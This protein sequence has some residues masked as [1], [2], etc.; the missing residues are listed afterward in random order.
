[1]QMTDLINKKKKG[2]ALSR[3]EISFLIK[4]ITAGEIPDYQ[5][6]ALCMAI[7]FQGMEDEETA[8]LTQAM[9]DSGDK[10]D[11][12]EFGSFSVDKHST[13]GVGDKTTLILAPLVA[14][15]GAKVAKMSGRGLGHT[16]GTV[17]KLEA[18]PGYR[19]RLPEEE[20]RQIARKAGV[21]VVG[22][23]AELAPADKKLYALRDVT[24]TV[25]S[26]PLIV[27]S[28]MSKKI[29]AGAHSIVLDVTVGSGAFMKTIEDARILAE[30][31]VTIG[32]ACGRRMTALITDMNEPLGHAVGNALEVREAI[33]VLKGETE[34][35][36]KEI[37]LALASEM[38][39]L[40]LEMPH[41]EA[42]ALA[43]ECLASGRAFE[44]CREWVAAQG[45]DV[46]YLMEPERF[47]EAAYSLMIPSPREGYLAA[48]DTQAIGEVACLLGA[49]RKR[50]EDSIDMAAGIMLHAKLGD[51]LEEGQPLATLYSEKEDSL[52]EAKT[53]YLEAL[54]FRKERI[55]K[56][57][58]IY[59]IIRES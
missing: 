42:R 52:R 43:E 3:E 4:G 20:F 24:G 58:L 22:Q 44:K 51:H 48:M 14:A 32:R 31:M 29:A 13:G 21:C 1:M 6:S 16:G 33:K 45:G 5:T 36:L 2:E 30:K 41:E 11:L 28:I 15:C 53:R 27:S 46:T 38:L 56:P 7:C 47:P 50:Q 10:L 26:I 59:D 19:T 25:D 12:S 49:G 35:D 57:R 34:G 39:H 37:C 18:I 8:C 40:S 17:D 54:C 23:S 55:E 9:A